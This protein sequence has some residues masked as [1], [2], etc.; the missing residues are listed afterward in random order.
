MRVVLWLVMAFSGR[1]D[2]L[3]ATD[4]L[5]PPGWKGN[6]WG[7][8]ATAARKSG[9]I[10]PVADTEEM[11]QWDRWGRQTLR[12]GDILF[13]RGDARVLRGMFPFSRFTANVTGSQFSHTG[14]V[15]LE[16]GEPM[17]Y[18]TTNPSVRRQPFK[19][20]VLDNTGPF[21]AKRLKPAY[22]DR[23]PKVVE[24]LRSV[25]EKQ[26]PFDWELSN[27]DRALYCLEMTE[28]A[29]RHAGL[30]LSEPV[31]LHNMENINEFPLC[32][33]VFTTV[34]PLK[35]DQAVFFPGNERHGVWSSP[36]LETI[37]SEPVVPSRTPP[38]AKPPALKPGPGRPT[39]ASPTDS[40]RKSLAG[41]D[42]ATPRN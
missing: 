15:V 6:P 9:E 7:P 14:T 8:A 33:L 11:K 22:R 10:P 16:D 4:R 1:H 39:A 2:G 17:V 20:W 29:F 28:K 35:L 25:Y 36:Y 40:G 18:D 19:V 23:I 30:P 31:V 24:Y 41:R 37:Y 32:V 13:R 21:G 42:G 27:D 38:R 12:T 26:V 3:E 5:V 34:S